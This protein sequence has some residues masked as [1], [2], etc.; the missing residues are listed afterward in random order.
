MSNE[1]ISHENN[2]AQAIEQ[3]FGMDERFADATQRRDYLG[4]L[5]GDDF[6]DLVQRTASL[7]RTGEAG[8]QDFDGDNVSLNFHDV[9]DQR[10][11]EQLVRE[12]WDV[13]KTFLND[14]SLPDDDA[15]DYAALTVAGGVLMAHPFADGNGRTTRAL[16]YMMA[17]GTEHPGELDEILAKTDG[18]GNWQVTPIPITVNGRSQFAGNQPDKLAWEFYFAGE[19]QDALGGAIANSARIQ[20]SVLRTFIESFGDVTEHNIAASLTHHED[21]TTTLDADKFIEELVNDP[22]AG[23]TNAI[24]LRKIH[25]ELRADYVHRFLSA[26]LID[27]KIKPRRIFPNELKVEEG[28]SPFERSRSKILINEVGKRSIDGMLSPADQ[29]LIQHRAYSRVYHDE[30]ES[31]AA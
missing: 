9:P 11:K 17:R 6:I 12:T 13:A 18:G 19:G 16:S 15:L 27:Q 26:M 21:G 22:N 24:E 14:P 1:L 29:Q 31:E 10:E 23:I 8:M 20:D 28:G 25:R 30:K 2:N 5:E 4:H 7:V 3:Y